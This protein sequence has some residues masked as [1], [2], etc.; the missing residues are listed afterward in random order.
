MNV[1]NVILFH[2]TQD[3][4]I[5]RNMKSQEEILTRNR[6]NFRTILGTQY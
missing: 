2:R 5:L 1:S 3:K 6:T 4:L